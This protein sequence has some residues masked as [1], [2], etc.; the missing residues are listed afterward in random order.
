MRKYA[1]IARH[2]S[3]QSHRIC[4]RFSPELLFWNVAAKAVSLILDG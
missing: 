1:K 3:Q 2:D 4:S